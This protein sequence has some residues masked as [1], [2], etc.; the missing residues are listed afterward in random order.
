MGRAKEKPLFSAQTDYEDDF[1]QW[2]AEQAELL[3]QKRFDE[4]DL[5]NVIEE[6]ESMGSEQRHALESSYRLLMAHL[7]KWTYQ[8]EK[9]SSSWEITIVRERTN[10]AQREERNRSL[11]ASAALIVEREYRR[12]VREAAVETGLPRA[13]FPADCPWTLSQLRDDDFLPE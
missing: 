9:R 3:R 8:P 4:V 2:C 11:A 13:S 12:A 1:H 5:P 7:L 10:V 6:L